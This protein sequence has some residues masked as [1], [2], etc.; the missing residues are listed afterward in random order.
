MRQCKDCGFLVFVNKSS[1]EFIECTKHARE[2]GQPEGNRK[3]LK[4]FPECARHS[5]AFVLE[6]T[7]NTDEG[8]RKA[9]NREHNCGKFIEWV[10]R[11]SP[12][13]HIDMISQQVLFEL[14]KEVADIQYKMLDQQRASEQAAQARHISNYVLVGVAIICG[15]VGA[16]FGSVLSESIRQLLFP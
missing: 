6:P 10:P 2:T 7:M 11:K 15:L 16:V 1:N 13:D 12:Q 8:R 3:Q 5:P 14:Q 9:F 4:E